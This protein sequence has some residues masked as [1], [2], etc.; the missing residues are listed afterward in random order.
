LEGGVS[1]R[2]VLYDL[3]AAVAADRTIGRM[4]EGGAR[5]IED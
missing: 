5:G 1:V 4:A 3:T 2:C